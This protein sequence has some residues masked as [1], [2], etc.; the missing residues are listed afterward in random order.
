METKDRLVIVVVILGWIGVGGVIAWALLH[1]GASIWTGEDSWWIAPTAIGIIA[2]FTIWGVD[3]LVRVKKLR[4]EGPLPRSLRKP[5]KVM[6][7]AV[8]LLF[9]VTGASLSLGIGIEYVGARLDYERARGLLT[10]PNWV[11]DANRTSRR[12]SI[13]GVMA[14]YDLEPR[15][16]GGGPGADAR[17]DIGEL[18]HNCENM[19][20]NCYHFLIWHRSTDWEDFQDFVIAAESSSILMARNFTCWLYLVPPSESD[21]KQ[22][23]PYGMDYIAWMNHSAQFSKLHPIVTAVCIDDFYGATE[24]RALFTPEYLESMRA[25]ADFYD[26]SLALVGCLYWSD[27]DPARE[28]ETWR[29]AA[30]IAPYIDGILYPYM[31]ESV[32]HQNHVYTGSLAEEIHRVNDVFPGIPAILDIYVSKHSACAELPSA[33]YVGAL[34]DG[35]RTCC[36]GVALYC[37]PKRWSN[38]TF[39]P[40]HGGMQDPAAIYAA[41]QSRFTI[42]TTEGW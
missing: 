37:G 3:V 36:D 6:I 25:T 4:T 5:A 8:S 20:V 33:I 35:S 40:W 27:V 39:G 17:V 26:P 41:I 14:D 42:W 10:D 32:H 38:G 22:S 15:L 31:D 34:L 23:E 7:A 19:S 29:Q 16:N 9:F 11:A 21:S 18:I 28:I 2:L 13:R 1:F 12:D 30:R 24:N